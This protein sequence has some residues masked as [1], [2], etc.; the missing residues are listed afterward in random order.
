MPVDR[1]RGIPTPT[2][3]HEG[4]PRSTSLTVSGTLDGEAFIHFLPPDVV[5][6][7]APPPVISPGGGTGGCDCT[8]GS[9]ILSVAD[10]VAAAQ[11]VVDGG[12]VD[13][14]NNFYG[15]FRFGLNAG[16]YSN[17]TP[18]V[19]YTTSPTLWLPP[20]GYISANS[21]CPGIVTRGLIFDFRALQNGVHVDYQGITPGTFQS[22]VI[23]D[24][25]TTGAHGQRCVASP[26]GTTLADLTCTAFLDCR[27]V[28][29]VCARG[30]FCRVSAKYYSELHTPITGIAML[31][32]DGT[33][34]TITGY[35]LIVNRNA[36]T[37]ETVEWT[38]SVP[39][40]Y[41]VLNSY[42]Y[43]PTQADWLF[44]N[45]WQGCQCPYGDTS[46]SAIHGDGPDG[47]YLTSYVIPD[48]G[49]T[50]NLFTSTQ[51]TVAD[52]SGSV[53]QAKWRALS[54]GA[55]LSL[56]VNNSNCDNLAVYRDVQVSFGYQS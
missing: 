38:G 30:Y 41:S 51:P 43:T 7:S 37:L 29:G 5:T 34:S 9:F 36:S 11:C 21:S 2:V 12:D 53:T 45:I 52:L 28:A 55:L 49:S 48:V 18:P 10:P 8:D 24:W 35:G 25:N 33:A 20:K 44:L 54:H 19:Y 1:N 16:L 4:N 32:N 6:F 27:S 23:D 26:D 17:T 39:G 13:A 42:A 22:L 56:P 14:C 50:F 15:D 40:S 47:G 31:T 3:A 46:G